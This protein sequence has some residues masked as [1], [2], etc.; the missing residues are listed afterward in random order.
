[1]TWLSRGLSRMPRNIVICSDGT[2]NTFDKG[3]SNVTRLIRLLALNDSQEQIVVYD[4]GIGANRKRLH[5]IREYRRIISDQ[6]SLIVLDKSWSDLAD[7]FIRLA[8]MLAGYG[9]RE[10]VRAMYRTLTELYVGPGDRVFLFGFSRGA[11]TVRA[12]AGIL[13]R[14]GLPPNLAGFDACFEQAWSLY[15]PVR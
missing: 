11:F 6:A 9:L 2:G 15:A 3:V 1:M 7:P 13:Y 5:S 14:C 4:Q 10:N 12:L 8:G